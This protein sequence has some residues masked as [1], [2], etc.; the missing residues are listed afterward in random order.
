MEAT[1][2]DKKVWTDEERVALAAKLDKDLED[3]IAEKSANPR[4]A[5]AA[6]DDTRTI[7]EI[8]DELLAH[9]AFMQEWDAS[10]PM[11]PAMEVPT[12]NL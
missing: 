7:D 4:A 5:A 8:A 2:K 6:E 11:S 3:F 12:A 10:K 1:N 9:P